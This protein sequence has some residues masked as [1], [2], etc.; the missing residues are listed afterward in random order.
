MRCIHIICARLECV[1][2]KAGE[3]YAYIQFK[4]ATMIHRLITYSHSL[5]N[6]IRL[7][8]GNVYLHRH[9]QFTRTL[10]VLVKHWG[11]YLCFK[12]QSWL[13]L[14][15]WQPAIKFGHVTPLQA[16]S[17]CL[18][19]IENPSR[20]KYGVKRCEVCKNQNSHKG[21][22]CSDHVAAGDKAWRTHVHTKGPQLSCGHFHRAWSKQLQEQPFPLYQGAYVS[23][24]TEWRALLPYFYPLH[25]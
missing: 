22:A 4:H 5:M 1:W 8:S 2:V 11:T 24:F 19:R 14:H 25:V 6:S 10:G 16:W 12:T 9:R 3:M 21:S 15:D 13:S 7:S 18:R 17:I 20:A 23:I